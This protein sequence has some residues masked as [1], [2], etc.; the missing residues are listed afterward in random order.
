VTHAAARSPNVPPPGG[1]APV[2]LNR[3]LSDQQIAE[4]ARPHGAAGRGVIGLPFLNDFLEPRWDYRAPAG[5]VTL[6]GQG[7]R[8]LE[9][10]AGL[11]GWASVGI[12]SDVDAGY[13]RDETPVEVDTAADW[14]RVGDVVP[15]GARDGV[16][17]GNWLRFLHEV[18]PER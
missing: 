6:R 11:A 12:G 17:G 10:V 14:R 3:H 16:L 5:E 4:V 13:G 9:H 8:H 1:R 2:P 18:L 15:E 7:R